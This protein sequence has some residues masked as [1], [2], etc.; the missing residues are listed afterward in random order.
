M[1]QA[2]VLL[3]DFMYDVDFFFFWGGGILWAAKHATHGSL[4][5]TSFLMIVW[6]DI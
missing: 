5:P 1:D 3:S 6:N 4:C 2:K